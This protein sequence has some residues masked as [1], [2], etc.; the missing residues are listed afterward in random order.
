MGGCGVDGA[1]D[2]EASSAEEGREAGEEAGNGGGAVAEGR[3]GE[4]RRAA[5]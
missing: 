4:R 2:G 5:G 1:R 3:G